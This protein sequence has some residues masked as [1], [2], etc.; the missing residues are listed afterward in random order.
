MSRRSDAASPVL[1]DRTSFDRHHE[2][3]VDLTYCRE[4]AVDVVQQ[5][6]FK[7]LGEVYIMNSTEDFKNFDRKAA[8]EKV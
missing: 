2:R 8:I 3:K 1:L 7:L 6:S 4:L 5:G